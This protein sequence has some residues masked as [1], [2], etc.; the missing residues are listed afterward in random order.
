MYV[1]PTSA[2]RG[3]RYGYRRY[4]CNTFNLKTA[5]FVWQSVILRFDLTLFNVSM[6]KK[7]T[8]SCFFLLKSL[9]YQWLFV[10]LQRQSSP[11]LLTMLKSCE[12]FF[13]YTHL[14]M[15]NLIPFTKRFE[16][17]ENLVD[18]LESRGLQICDRNKAIQYLDNI[19]YYRL[20]AYMYPLLKMPKTAH[21][22]KE[23]STFKKVMMLYRFDKKLRL[24]M[25]NEIKKIEMEPLW[26]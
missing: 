17:S 16:S 18:L 2:H 11:S 26:R 22:Y 3:F 25:F 21:L 23:G 20:S 14:N 4:K 7:F 5:L 6:S 12:A 1:C 9:S 13:V 24:L 10:S 15:A 19:G 8:L